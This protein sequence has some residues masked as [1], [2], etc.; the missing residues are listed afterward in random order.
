[1]KEFPFLM[2]EVMYVYIWFCLTT[3]P[4]NIN[5]QPTKGWFTTFYSGRGTSCRS[6]VYARH[7][8][9][10]FFTTIQ[11]G[12]G[13]VCQDYAIFWVW[14]AS[15]R[16]GRE[17]G[18]PLGY[19]NSK[20]SNVSLTTTFTHNRTHTFVHY[21]LILMPPF[22]VKW[23]HQQSVVNKCVEQ[24]TFKACEPRNVSLSLLSALVDNS[25]HR[26]TISAMVVF[27]AF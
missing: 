25:L 5:I 15:R 10:L 24:S 2:N 21:W 3:A 6:A 26:F 12:K 27:L 1:M 22:G 11:V 9:M 17:S 16:V 23:M 8:V 13:V 4:C 20:G 19:L 14:T 7:I 18:N